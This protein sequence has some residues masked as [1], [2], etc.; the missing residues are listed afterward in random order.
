MTIKGFD[1]FRKAI[2]QHLVAIVRFVL[3]LGSSNDELGHGI[4]ELHFDNSVLIIKPGP[5][6][7]YII[8]EEGSVSD[9]GLN[10]EYWTQVN[11]S[12][13]SKWSALVGHRLECVECYNDGFEDVAL[14]FKLDSEAHFSIVLID[15]DLVIAKGLEP[16][17]KHSDSVPQLR[18]S[19]S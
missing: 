2:G 14:I 18:H 13:Q 19:I 7:D 6:E 10:P 15:T 9:L 8:V 11:L 5:N 1:L 4:T 17:D 16:F 3:G 12:E